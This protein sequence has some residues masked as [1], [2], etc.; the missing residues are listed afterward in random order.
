M[1][2]RLEVLLNNDKCYDIVIEESF[3]GLAQELS[4]LY[5]KKRKLCVITDS[6]VLE[7]YAD[8]VRRNL[9]E[10]FETV[11][12][13]EFK[14]GE[15]NKN[16][17]TVSEAYQFL[18]ENRFN[19]RDVIIALGGGVTGDL[20]GFT[21]S[22]YMRGIDFVQIPTTLLSMADSSIGGKTGVDFNSYKN[23]VGAFYMPK[24][25]YI[26]ISTLASLDGRQFSSGMAEILKAGLIKDGA[27]YEWL[28]NGFTPIMDREI[29]YL[30][31]M[32]YESVRIK[33]DVVSKDPFEKGERALLNF[34]HT[35]G[36]AIE[37]YYD[38]KLTHGECVALGSCSAAFISY[39]RGLIEMEDYYEIRDMFVPFGLPIS[40]EEMDKEN[41]AALTASDK[42]NDENGLKFILLEGIGNAVIKRDV[43]REEMLLALSELTGE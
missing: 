43:S 22:T 36:H 15:E 19:R 9:S 40:A 28:I 32:V 25:V 38:F 7:F 11:L 6:N 5:D 21:A 33:R 35:L 3:T 37:K 26:N 18:I 29:S 34:G 24:L 23:M 10:C 17:G 39:K 1:D 20:S 42:K 14:A 13:F 16:L 41:V 30:K 8:E 2:S 12:V 27:F 4:K 31:K